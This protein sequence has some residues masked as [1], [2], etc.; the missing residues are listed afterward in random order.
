MVRSLLL[1]IKLKDSMSH[2]HIVFKLVSH[3]TSD[4]IELTIHKGNEKP[5]IFRLSREE[6]TKAMGA[7]K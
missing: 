5:F 2:G 3:R 7:M 6:L 4:T 1:E